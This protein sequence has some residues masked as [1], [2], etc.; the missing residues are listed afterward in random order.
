MTPDG[1]AAL[2]ELAK[3]YEKKAD[4]PYSSMGS[5]A[6][7]RGIVKAL[8]AIILTEEE[9]AGDTTITIYEAG[10]HHAIATVPN[11]FSPAI[12]RETISGG[13]IEDKAKAETGYECGCGKA[14][15]PEKTVCRELQG[16]LCHWDADDQKWC[17]PVQKYEA[18][19]E[20]E[21]TPFDDYEAVAGVLRGIGWNSPNDAQW[22]HLRQLCKILKAQWP[23]RP[24]PSDGALREA[25]EK[26]CKLAAD[27]HVEHA[28]G[29]QTY[30][31]WMELAEATF[32]TQAI[33]NSTAP[34]A[35]SEG[36]RDKVIAQLDEIPTERIM[37]ANGI[38]AQ[39][40]EG[41]WYSMKFG[42]DTLQHII[43]ALD[44]YHAPS[45]GSIPITSEMLRAAGHNGYV[46][47]YGVAQR[48]YS[49]DALRKALNKWLDRL[50][51]DDL[52]KGWFLRSL[53]RG[54]VDDP[55]DWERNDAALPGSVA[56]AV[57]TVKE[58][59]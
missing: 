47:G 14:I 6:E 1:L 55:E 9:R 35:P 8:S 19:A 17:S 28:K 45:D 36:V 18:K 23:T 10:S 21:E 38:G 25:A 37:I 20:A 51:S 31:K 56:P 59:K 32:F 27:Y 11:P 43:D 29:T 48:Y 46:R 58:E 40:I 30:E 54:M 13:P 50:N 24:A 44:S 12:D 5:R 49:P 16:I 34:T 3:K 57:E 15:D 39:M 33:L 41:K 26:V 52:Y 4:A 2:R 22:D 7:A 53:L 42:C